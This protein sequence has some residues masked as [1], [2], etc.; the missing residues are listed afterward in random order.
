MVVRIRRGPFA[1][2]TAERGGGET[3]ARP[4]GGVWFHID[5][6]NSHKSKVKN[7]LRT[8]NDVR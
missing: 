3:D 5:N 2:M 7:G 8:V 6:K 1:R 4:L